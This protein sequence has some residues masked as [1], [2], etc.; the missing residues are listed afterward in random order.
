MNDLLL[1]TDFEEKIPGV[2]LPAL[3]MRTGLLRFG[4]VRAFAGL[5]RRRALFDHLDLVVAADRGVQRAAV[6]GQGGGSGRR[7]G[8]S[9]ESEG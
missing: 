6:G 5:A 2:I 3:G 8:S 9:I 4:H 7:I 1:G